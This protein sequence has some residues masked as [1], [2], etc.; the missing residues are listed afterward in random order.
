MSR[1]PQD[2]GITLESIRA[3]CQ[4]KENEKV[5]EE[6]GEA[7]KIDTTNWPKT[8]EALEEYLR[9]NLGVT[10][11]LLLYVVR[12][13]MEVPP[14]NANSAAGTANSPYKMVEAELI[15]RAPHNTN[16]HNQTPLPTYITDR[17]RVWEL[18]SEIARHHECW[19]HVKAAQ[20]TRDSRLAFR[21]LWDHYLGPNNIYNL[22]NASELRLE[23]ISYSGERKC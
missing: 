23:S 19:M 6:P 17:Q 3:L 11:V 9:S 18:I 13:T 20:R 12:T 16:G 4:L 5:H 21:W 1:V 2:R 14:A 10:K 22:E 15:V 8:L 7:P